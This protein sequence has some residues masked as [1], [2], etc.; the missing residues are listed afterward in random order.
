MR[1]PPVIHVASTGVA[2]APMPDGARGGCPLP[3]SLHLS[4]PVPSAPFAVGWGG[5]CPGREGRTGRPPVRELRPAG[6]IVFVWGWRA[7]PGP[8]WDRALATHG[9]DSDRSGPLTPELGLS[10]AEPSAGGPGPQR[11]YSTPHTDRA[12]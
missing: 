10:C 8:P 11:L 2:A 1:A 6:L 9:P 3:P 5:F 4:P 7:S 12:A